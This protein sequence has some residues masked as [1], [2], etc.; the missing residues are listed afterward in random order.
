[1]D[2]S[3]M[4]GLMKTRGDVAGN[5]GDEYPQQL[6]YLDGGQAHA[7][8]PVHC[9]EHLG[10]EALHLSVD[11]GNGHRVFLEN[12]IAELD[13]VEHFLCPTWF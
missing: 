2:V 1:M 5:L 12:R 7:P 11:V 9:V 3:R 10:H 13:D 6:P 8:S 4:S